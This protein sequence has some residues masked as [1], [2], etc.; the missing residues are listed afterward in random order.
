[1]LAFQNF[2]ERPNCF[3]ER[4]V[5]TL[6]AGELF[7]HEE[8]LGEELL[9]FA[10][11]GNESFVVFGKFFHTE[12]GN[13]VLQIFVALEHALDFTGDIVMVFTHNVR[14]KNR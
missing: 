14:V 7:G 12:D 4:N 9:D 6:R 2:L 8:R 10:G 3:G 5:L 1:M 11:A 13:D